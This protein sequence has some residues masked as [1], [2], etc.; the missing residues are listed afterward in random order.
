MSSEIPPDAPPTVV[1]ESLPNTYVVPFHYNHPVT[2]E[3]HAD[4]DR[5]ARDKAAGKNVR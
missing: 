4:M 2:G 5:L 1:Y 3:P